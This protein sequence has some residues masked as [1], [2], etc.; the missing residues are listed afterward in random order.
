MTTL[1]PF[2]YEW[3]SRNSSDEKKTLKSTTTPRSSNPTQH[4]TPREQTVPT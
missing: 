1:G 4:K 2:T 3:G